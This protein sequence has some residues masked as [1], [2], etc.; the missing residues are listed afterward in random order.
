MVREFRGVIE[1]EGAEMGLFVCLD[2]PTREME[3]EAVIA[4][5][6]RT[7]HG[8]LPRLQIMSIADWFENR[9]PQLP[10]IEMLPYAAFSKPSR[11][12][13]GRLPDP[14][15]PELPLVFTKAKVG[16]DKNVHTNPQRVRSMSLVG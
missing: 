16:K 1:R 4:G 6:A 2:E 11:T 5:N 7:T 15:E 10:P 3:R 13:E 9:R 12:A 14:N 8:T